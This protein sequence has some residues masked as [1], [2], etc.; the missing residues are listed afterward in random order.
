MHIYNNG[1][2]LRSFKGT[3]SPQEGE[4]NS[5]KESEQRTL[6]VKPV[7]SNIA[8]LWQLSSNSVAM[9][10]IGNLDNQ[11]VI[12]NFWDDGEQLKPGLVPL[13]LIM[14]I[15]PEKVLGLCAFENT[16]FYLRTYELEKK[17]TRTF[18]FSQY[19]KDLGLPDP[20][21]SVIAID[22]SQ[23]TNLFFAAVALSQKSPRVIQVKITKEGLQSVSSLTIE[24]PDFKKIHNISS[25]Q[26]G[27]SDYILAS[28][29]NSL[30]LMVS[31]DKN[32]STLHVFG[33]LVAG[34]IVNS[35]ISRNK[36]FCVSPGYPFIIE[37]TAS[38]KVDEKQI[39]DM[40]KH[41]QTEDMKN[42]LQYEKYNIS[43]LEL[44]NNK[45]NRVEVT[46]KGDA[47]YAIGRGIMVITGLNSSKPVKSDVYFESKKGV[48]R[49][50]ILLGEE[51]K[52]WEYS[53]SRHQV[54]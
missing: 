32:I 34:E 18:E 3:P 44:T 20:Q 27:K 41:Y 25:Y 48:I 19:S 13:T 28:G 40:Q 37:I 54:K 53:S 2:L 38:N 30:V 50:A 12:D 36:F 4:K 14:N 23:R 46:K 21:F 7:Y 51:F 8:F 11:T 17:K 22:K 15:K 42:D 52:K 26:I 16:K 1:E 31:K 35:C 33:D 9:M 24:I 5:Q 47:L 29:S 43:K 49:Q 10:N 39:Q 45:F 6:E